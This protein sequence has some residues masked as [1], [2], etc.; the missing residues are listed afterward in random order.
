[1]SRLADALNAEIVQE[2]VTNLREATGWLAY[3]YLFV[4]MLNKPSV[5]HLDPEDLKDDPNLEQRRIDLAHS[6]AL[7]LD[8]SNLIKYDKKSGNFQV[9]ELGRVCAH[10]YLTHT[11]IQTFNEHL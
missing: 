11:T 4:R 7:L 1:M 5:Y 10:Y 3:T 6:A 2:S 8:K 9:T